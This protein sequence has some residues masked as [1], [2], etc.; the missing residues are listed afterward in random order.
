[1]YPN[2]MIEANLPLRLRLMGVRMT[3]LQSMDERKGGITKVRTATGTDSRH[4]KLT[5]YIA[6][7]MLAVWAHPSIYDQQTTRQRRRWPRSW[8]M[9]A[10]MPKTPNAPSATACWATC[11]I[12]RSI[13]TL[14]SASTA[15]SWPTIP[16]PS[17][18]RSD[19]HRLSSTGPVRPA[20]RLDPAAMR[21][22]QH[23]QRTAR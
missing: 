3:A 7:L 1:M 5:Q 18:G 20:G 22:A 8:G 23:H 12:Q 16:S 19:Q 13:D 4:V 11:P 14:T 2:Q 17:S 21:A 9:A 6:V 15:A 10:T